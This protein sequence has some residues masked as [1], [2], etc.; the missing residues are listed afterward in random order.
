MT[1]DTRTKRAARSTLCA[2]AIAVTVS[3]AG[4]DQLAYIEVT[5]DAG[6]EIFVDGGPMGK[7]PLANS[8]A[9]AP[10][11]HVV[12]IRKDG[13]SARVTIKV[14]GGATA[15]AALTLGP[16]P[17]AAPVTAP[18]AAPA[19]AS[20]APVQPAE[21]PGEPPAA[22]A[23]VEADT[24]GSRQPFVPWFMETPLAWVGGGLTALGVVGGV[25]FS[26]LASRNYGVANDHGDTIRERKASDGYSGPV[27]ASPPPGYGGACDKFTDARDLGDGQRTISTVSFVVAGAAAAGTVVYYLLS[28][29][30]RPEAAH[31]ARRWAVVPVANVESRGAAVLGTF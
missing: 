5:A 7:A 3:V 10:G 22:E 8:L 15:A 30:K 4:A 18:A 2:L 11:E 12:E 13:R 29:K 1:R 19:G 16:A 14:A 27:C 9:V 24:G 25:T 28:A 26:V 21:Q 31:A 17:A 6:A 20:A 23:A